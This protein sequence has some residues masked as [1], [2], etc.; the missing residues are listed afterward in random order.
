MTKDTGWDHAL[1][2]TG[3]GEGLAGHAGAVLLRKLADRA[4]LTAALGPRAGQVRPVPAGGPGYRAGEHGGGDRARGHQHERHRPAGGAPGTGLRGRTVGY[5]GTPAGFPWLTVAG[6]LELA[7]L[8]GELAGIGR[9]S[10]IFPPASTI[11]ITGGADCVTAA[12][13]TPGSQARAGLR[14]YANGQR[15]GWLAAD[16][17]SSSLSHGDVTQGIRRLLTALTD[18]PRAL[19]GRVAIGVGIGRRVQ[20]PPQDWLSPQDLILHEQHVA[21]HLGGRL[22]A[23][24]AEEAP[25]GPPN[26]AK[27]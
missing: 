4:G 21:D 12:Q 23:L 8:H 1:K 9:R 27:A 2:V 26:P 18:I 16:S 22:L 20:L 19:P 11:N 5:H 10:A 15:S 3:S 7:D 13:S 6:K 14:I 24:L 25:T 17:P